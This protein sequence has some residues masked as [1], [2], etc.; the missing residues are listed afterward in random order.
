MGGEKKWGKVAGQKD[1]CDA[2]VSE[3]EKGFWSCEERKSRSRLK[4]MKW[5]EEKA[6]SE[7][8]SSLTAEEKAML[9]ASGEEQKKR[10]PTRE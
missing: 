1:G 6:D 5:K 3:E 2:G 8:G 4:T 7:K 9:I 10:A